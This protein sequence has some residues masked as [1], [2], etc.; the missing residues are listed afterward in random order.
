MLYRGVLVPCKRGKKR[1]V[2]CGGVPIRGVRCPNNRGSCRK[3]PKGGQKH[4]GR[5][6]GGGMC[7]VS[8]IQF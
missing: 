2:L 6:F 4:V 1:C 7:I 8:N 3:I 5:R